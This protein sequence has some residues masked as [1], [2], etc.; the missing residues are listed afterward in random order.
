RQ[1][2]LPH[3]VDLPNGSVTQTPLYDERSLDCER[4][5]LYE[6]GN[7]GV[8]S[9]PMIASGYDVANNNQI[10]HTLTFKAFDSLP[11]GYLRVLASDR[12]GTP[13]YLGEAGIAD[14][15]KGQSA[16]VTLGNAFDLTAKRERTAFS[17]DRANR[18][19]DASF[20]ITLSNA[21]DAPR[22][23]TV[24]EHPNRWHE[25]QLTSSSIKPSKQTPDTLDFK[26]NVPS[27]GTATLEY[28]VRY[29]WSPDITPQ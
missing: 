3:P 29:H 16:T 11:A 28:S 26:I 5:A 13:Q 17:V 6:N 22:V 27:N 19:M 8:P 23:V 21:G 7:W 2:T 1:Y 25:W 14:T 9:Q 18:H 24:R 20:K 15:A 4:T 12:D 10:T